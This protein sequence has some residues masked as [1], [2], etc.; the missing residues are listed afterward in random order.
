MT[1]RVC[2][3]SGCPTLTRGARCT[4]HERAKDKARG[5]RQQRGYD[6]DYDR[7]RAHYAR[8]MAAGEVFTCWRCEELGRPHPVDPK[9]WHLGHSNDDRSVILGPQCAASN[10]ATSGSP[11]PAA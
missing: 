10:L 8:R 1:V 4:E 6:A 3:E 2:I 11:K 9:A 7:E 5:T